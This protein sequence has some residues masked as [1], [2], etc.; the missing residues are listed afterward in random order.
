MQDV[1]DEFLS[2]TAGDRGYYFKGGSGTLVEKLA[3]RILLAAP[4]QLVLK[5]ASHLRLCLYT[6]EHTIRDATTYRLFSFFFLLFSP[7]P[8]Q[9]AKLSAPG[10]ATTREILDAVIAIN[11]DQAAADSTTAAKQQSRDPLTAALEGDD[12]AEAAGSADDAEDTEE[13]MMIAVPYPVRLLLLIF[14]G[15]LDPT[16]PTRFSRPSISAFDSG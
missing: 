13:Q 3:V 8:P 5:P 6:H 16:L 7:S 15:L 9:A 4:G 11:Q 12:D 10:E 14:C 1:L 2:K